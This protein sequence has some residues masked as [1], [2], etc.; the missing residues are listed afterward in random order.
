MKIHKNT[1][2]HASTKAPSGVWKFVSSSQVVSVDFLRWSSSILFCFPNMDFSD[3]RDSTH[4]RNILP[5]IIVQSLIESVRRDSLVDASSE[6]WFNEIIWILPSCLNSSAIRHKRYPCQLKP[7]E[8]SWNIFKMTC[9]LLASNFISISL[10]RCPKQALLLSLKN[11][12]RLGKRNYEIF[13][14]HFSMCIKLC[15]HLAEENYF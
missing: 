8:N 14:L 13:L 15:L 5:A 10:S 3:F 6:F 4:A 2:L 12:F 7:K 1:F 11:T 9:H